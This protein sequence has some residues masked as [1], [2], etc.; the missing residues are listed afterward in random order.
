MHRVITRDEDSEMQD[1]VPQKNGLD[2]NKDLYQL[3]KLASLANEAYIENVEADMADWI[4]RGVPTDRALVSGPLLLG[5]S[6]V[7]LE[8]DLSLIDRLPFEAVNRFQ[9]AIYNQGE[10]QPALVAIS[11]APEDLLAKATMLETDQGLR[12]IIASDR[13]YFDKKLT[14]LATAGFRVIGLAYVERDLEKQDFTNQVLVEMVKDV[15]FVGVVALKDPLRPDVKKS[16]KL[17]QKAGIRVVIATGDHKRTAKAVGQEIGLNPKDNEVMEGIDLDKLS[18]DEFSKIVKKI[19]IFARVEPKHKMRIIAAWQGHGEIVAMTGDG[20]N[21]APA[22]K[23]SDIGLA[24]GSGT[25]VAKEASDLILLNDSF[26]II[27]KAVEEGRII[28][29][30]IRKSIAYVL[31]DSFAS[32]ILIGFAKIIFGWPI[33]ILPAQILWNNLVEDTLPSIAY[34][35]EPGEKGVMDRKPNPSH[36]SLFTKEMKVL[37]FITGIIDQFIALFLFWYLWKNLGLSLE[38]T[39]TIVFGTISIDTAFIV[40]SY[41][42]LRKNIWQINPFSNKILNLSSLLVFVLFGAVIY[43]PFLRNLLHTVILGWQDWL[44]ICGASILSMILVEGTKW[45]FISRHHTED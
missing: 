7:D 15:V 23:K 11:G 26:S 1:L 30:N 18:D 35:F 5:I 14:T 24:L 40:F 12:K 37:I 28:L 9:T 27:V 31:S 3:L 45:I 4:I 39:R 10:R 21:D 22:L 25:E 2:K 29:D 8:K 13:D 36:T 20:V 33:P 19:K 43:V 6:K 17:A 44:L 16:I 34:A 42:N 41:K 32:M 38:Y